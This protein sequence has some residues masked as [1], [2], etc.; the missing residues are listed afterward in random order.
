M[1]KFK[2]DV[3]HN[4]ADDVKDPVSNTQNSNGFFLPF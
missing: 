4:H 1:R 3:W 2:N